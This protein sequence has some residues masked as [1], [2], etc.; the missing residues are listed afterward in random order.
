MHDLKGR[1]LYWIPTSLIALNWTFG[2]VSTLLKTPSS[3]EVF[4]RL[5]YPEY[6]AAMLGVAQ[7]L[8]VAAILVP[9]PRVVREWAYAGM[10]FDAIAAII[11]LLAIGMPIVQA[12]FPLVA[13]ALVLASYGAWKSRV[14]TIGA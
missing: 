7:L 2:G 13:L 5:G 3:M 11:S 4:S 14:K 1:L 6:F 8:G 9:L 10:A 12:G